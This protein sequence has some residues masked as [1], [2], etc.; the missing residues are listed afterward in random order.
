MIEMATLLEA[1]TLLRRLELLS[2]G[3]TM[4]LAP[5]RGGSEGSIYPPGG[6]AGKDDREPDHPHKS[7]IHYRRRLGRCRTDEHV[8]AV[9]DDMALALYAWQHSAPPPADSAAWKEQ[10]ARDPGHVED[11]AARWNIKK[12]YVWQ[13]RRQFGLGRK[14]A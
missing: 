1:R 12:A 10:V 13:L 7:H 4:K 6:I 9:I 5:T 3:Q 14:A 8:Q 11:V 2:H